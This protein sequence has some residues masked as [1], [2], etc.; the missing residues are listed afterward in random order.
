VSWAVYGDMGTV[1]PFGAA[2]TDM[3][4]LENEFDPFDIVL[5]VGDLAYAGVSSGGEWEPTWD[6]WMNQI[7][8]LSS[9]IPYQTSVGNHE[10]Y[11]EFASF[12][13]R[14]DMPNTVGGNGNFWF[15]FDYGNI[16]VTSFSTEN[17]D[18]PGSAQ[19]A[20]IEKDLSEAR[21]RNTEW[22]FVSCHR[23]LLCSD[24]SEY[25]SH[26]PGSP[27]ISTLEPLFIKYGVDLVLTG[28]MHCYERTYPY[29]NG[30]V[31][32]SSGQDYF[33]SPGAPIYMT[34]G[35]AGAMIAETWI[36]P[37]PNWS[38]NRQQ[39]Y[40]FGRLTVEKFSNGTNLLHYQFKSSGNVLDQ[41]WVQK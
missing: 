40:G 2:V 20:W 28:H 7:S 36:D 10:K 15:S 41:F 3:L 5:H 11:F 6:A 1:V 16:H 39:E 21:D 24:S 13:N 38:A 17:D 29:Y 25:G 32:A 8:P 27:R 9:I 31:Y 30:T 22:I 33:V 18:G 35:T 37:Q 26:S 12:I 4:I 23:P 19:L 34:Q 14:F